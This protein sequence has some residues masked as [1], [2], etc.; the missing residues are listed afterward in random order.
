[1]TPHSWRAYCVTQT[2]PALSLR[3]ELR[4]CSRLHCRVVLK[5]GGLK[6]VAPNGQSRPVHLWLRS[7]STPR[8]SWHQFCSVP[9]GAP[10]ASVGPMGSLAAA[11]LARRLAMVPCAAVRRSQL[12]H[13][14]GPTTGPAARPAWQAAYLK[15]AG[16]RKQRA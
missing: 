15:P 8:G 1:M 11:G 3:G 4:G 5:N 13:P 9:T 16:G 12:R 10:F 2:P 7:R 6:I 14:G